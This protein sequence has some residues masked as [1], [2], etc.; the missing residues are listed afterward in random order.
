MSV[1]DKIIAN[2]TAIMSYPAATQKL[3]NTI[4][5]ELKTDTL[6]GVKE[7]CDSLTEDQKAASSPICNFFYELHTKFG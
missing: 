4:L 7:N 5:E 1:G 6:P 3:F 2:I